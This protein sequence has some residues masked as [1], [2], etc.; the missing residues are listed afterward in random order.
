MDGLEVRREW[1]RRAFALV[2]E[3]KA[4][5]LDQL[6]LTLEKREELSSLHITVQ[7]AT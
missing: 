3:L 4:R 5:T 6:L 2:V 7:N 1:R